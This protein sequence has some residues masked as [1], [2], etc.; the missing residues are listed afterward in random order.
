MIYADLDNMKPI[1]D[2]HG[3]EAGDQALQEVARVL[4][5][6]L[7][8]SDLVARFGGDEFCAL[9]VG[10]AAQ[11]APSL[12][13]RLESALAERNAT[14]ARPWTLSVSLGLAECPIDADTAVWDLVAA[15]DARMFEAK[16]E[17]KKGRR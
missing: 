16:R 12:I 9:L 7:R 15:A 4:E 2:T 1:N 6:S 10:G 14:A 5:S 3:H 17:K 8:A 13:S 11:A